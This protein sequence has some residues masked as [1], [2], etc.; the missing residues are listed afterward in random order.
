MYITPYKWIHDCFH[1]I[2]SNDS[3]QPRYPH[4]PH[5]PDVDIRWI[6]AYVHLMDT[7]SLHHT[8]TLHTTYLLPRALPPHSPRRIHAP[9]NET[10]TTK[11]AI[12]K[13]LVT[14]DAQQQTPDDHRDR[15]EPT[16]TAQCQHL[17]HSQLTVKSSTLHREAFTGT[18]VIFLIIHC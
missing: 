11:T 15:R 17:V 14:P 3:T 4:D 5:P 18:L 10:K 8:T 1:R 7:L 16:G 2:H 13:A 6:R 12:N 9:I